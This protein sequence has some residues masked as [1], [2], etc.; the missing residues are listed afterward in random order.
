M[1]VGQNEVDD[2]ANLGD[3]LPGCARGARSLDDRSTVAQK[4][5]A[6]RSAHRID[7]FTREFSA[8]QANQVQSREFDVVSKSH[9]VGNNVA[10]DA[11][12][13]SD[14]RALTDAAT[15]LHG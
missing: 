7:G 3:L 6:K 13:A 2:F 9:G 5:V 10:V 11:R 15:L 4:D 14:H 1:R 12:Y 8:L